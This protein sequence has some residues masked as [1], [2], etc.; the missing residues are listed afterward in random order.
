MSQVMYC[1]KGTQCFLSFPVTLGGWGVLSLADV[2]LPTYL[3]THHLI[4]FTY[5]HLLLTCFLTTP[6]LP[7]LFSS[8]FPITFLLMN[9]PIHWF[10]LFTCFSPTCSRF[11]LPTFF[12]HFHPSWLISSHLPS[13][14]FTHYL[15]CALILFTFFLTSL[16]FSLANLFFNWVDWFFLTWSYF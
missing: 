4:H 9:S 7:T 10:F 3:F 6:H 5:A 1:N 13:H 16:L 12:Y 8:P 14:L 2:Y 15:T 11:H